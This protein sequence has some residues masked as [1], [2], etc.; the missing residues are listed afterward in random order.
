M[1][2]RRN[3]VKVDVVTLRK[4]GYLYLFVPILIF[5]M[6]WIR[7]ELSISCVLMAIV[8]IWTGWRDYSMGEK[9]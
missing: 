3:N 2:I 1:R 5:L 8:A 9:T 7:I 6:G 4:M